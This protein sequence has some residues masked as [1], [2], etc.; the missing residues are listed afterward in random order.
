MIHSIGDRMYT[1]CVS[2][3]ISSPR[4]QGQ[5]QKQ[6]RCGESSKVQAGCMLPHFVFKQPRIS[7][8]Q[9][10]SYHNPLPNLYLLHECRIETPASFDMKL[11]MLASVSVLVSVFGTASASIPSF[12]LQTAPSIRDELADSAFV[13][14]PSRN[15]LVRNDNFRVEVAS[16]STFPVLAGTD[17][18]AQI[19]RVTLRAGEPFIR[20]IHPRSSE[21]LTVIRGTFEVTLTTEGLEPRTIRNRLLTGQ[22]TVFPQGLPHVQRCVSKRDCVFQAVFASADP[23]FVPV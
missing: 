23:G 20:H 15:V 3:E 12:G 17:V 19:T 7:V 6:T 5:A 2:V 8:L 11:L 14:D 22:S 18:Q 4:S 1:F 21:V 10:L 9:Q 13:I 16:L